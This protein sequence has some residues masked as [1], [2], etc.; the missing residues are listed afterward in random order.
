MQL[1]SLHFLNDY[2][3]TPNEISKPKPAKDQPA[4]YFV[5]WL[6]SHSKSPVRQISQSRNHLDESIER[7]QPPNRRERYRCPLV[8]IETGRTNTPMVI[9]HATPL[10]LIDFSSKITGW[11]IGGRVATRLRKWSTQEVTKQR[12]I[13][14]DLS[15][16]WLVRLAIENF[17]ISRNGTEN[18]TNDNVGQGES[19]IS[20]IIYRTHANRI[21]CWSREKNRSQPVHVPR[22]TLSPSRLVGWYSRFRKAAPRNTSD[23]AF[24]SFSD[25]FGCELST[26]D[27]RR[28]ERRQRISSKVTQ[29]SM[30]F[31]IIINLWTW[32]K[33]WNL[34]RNLLCLL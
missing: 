4:S 33:N 10:G 32:L 1:I 31:S 30:R 8:W 13:A 18:V 12:F 11:L 3:I 6:I 24:L 15:L 23:S 7:N 22:A 27:R 25:F 29:A 28:K 5:D 16:R 19:I 20:N 34:N 17:Q 21:R 14:R 9:C 26:G 2:K